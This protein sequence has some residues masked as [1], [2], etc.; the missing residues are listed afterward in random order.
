MMDFLQEL[1]VHFVATL[2]EF[3]EDVVVCDKTVMVM[4]RAEGFD[5]NDIAVVLVS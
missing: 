2:F 4:F 3:P 5:K 1:W